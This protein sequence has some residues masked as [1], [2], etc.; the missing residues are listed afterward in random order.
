MNSRSV[1]RKI[2]VV[3]VAVML[4]A[5]LPACKSDTSGLSFQQLSYVTGYDFLKAYSG[6]YDGYLCKVVTCDKTKLTIPAEYEGKPVVAV[7]TEYGRNDT[8]KELVIPEGVKYVEDAFCNYS[9]LTK[10]TIP[11][12]IK[13]IYDSFNNCENLTEIFYDGDIQTVS[14]NSFNNII[15]PPSETT[16]ATTVTVESITEELT[17]WDY[18]MLH[19]D[20]IQAD[21]EWISDI[22]GQIL[23]DMV[24]AGEVT[25]SNDLSFMLTG[26][27]VDKYTGN[28]F[29]L[30]GKIIIAGNYGD[31]ENIMTY[32]RSVFDDQSLPYYYYSQVAESSPDVSFASTRDEC[33]YLIII[34]GVSSVESGFYEGGIDRT[35]ISTEVVII[36][37]EDMSVIHI[38]HIGT[39][40]PGGV[41][42]VTTGKLM[43]FEAMEYISS[44]V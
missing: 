21:M 12:S 16:V 14:N 41:T 35:S 10:V 31:G 29:T 6:F 43:E 27:G 44:V 4:F 3:L 36:D 33:K 22:W 7:T 37:V 28:D 24:S 5:L 11:N 8:L 39:D 40:A 20:D 23:G 30:D 25:S 17:E 42:Q 9:A 34:L 1:L 15:S 32:T 2:A 18:M 38:E 19:E 13:D 26:V